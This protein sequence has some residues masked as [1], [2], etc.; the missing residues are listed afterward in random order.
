[1]KVRFC[2]VSNSSSSSWV[3][4]SFNKE[5]FI[6]LIKKYIESIK[7]SKKENKYY[8]NIDKNKIHECFMSKFS[9]NQE[10]LLETY[11]GSNLIWHY[12]YLLIDYYSEVREY[13]FS[14]CK[15][16]KDDECNSCYWQW[17]KRR[18]DETNK[19][20][21]HCE[22]LF[23]DLKNKEEKER[24]KR[25]VDTFEMRLERDRAII[26]R[27]YNKEQEFINPLEEKYFNLW[28]EKNKDT[29]IFSFASDIGDETEAYLRYT[30]NRL[31][32]FMNENGLS[33]FCGE[34]S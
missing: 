6:D 34:N 13:S 21:K 27:D 18:I 28:K 4:T 9:D 26:I 19:A 14:G 33:G 20:I 32:K 2:Y 15:T 12:F 5:M 7:I 16:C 22:K 3:C 30:V 11:I 29:F 23:H 31:A 25:F 8:K 24:V 10:D 1:M 17:K